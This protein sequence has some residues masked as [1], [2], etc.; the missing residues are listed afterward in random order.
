MKNIPKDPFMLVSYINT[1]MRDYY[2]TLDELCLAMGMDKKEI[3]D[4]LSEAGFEYDEKIG[5]FF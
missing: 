3:C 2:G 4:R 1:Q 5:R